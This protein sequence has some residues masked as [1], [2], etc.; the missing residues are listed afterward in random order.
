M[1]AVVNYPPATVEGAC[2]VLD[3]N[4]ASGSTLPLGV[5]T[6]TVTGA[7][8]TS[9][10]FNVT[11]TGPSAASGLIISE[12]RPRGIAGDNDEFIELYN[13][14]GADLTISTSDGSSGWAVAASDGVARC[15]VPNG[16]V[17][18]NRGHYLCVNS[19]GYSLGTYPAG[20]G[21]TATGDATYTTG[22]N[23]NVGI[24]L[25]NTANPANFTLAN[26]LDAVGSTSEANS[27]YREGPG[28]APLSNPFSMSDYSLFRNLGTGSPQDTNSNSAD[29]LYADTLATER[30]LG[31]RLGGPGPENLSSPIQRN[32]T[33]KASLIFPCVSSSADPNRVRDLTPVPVTGPLGTLEIRR[34]F[35][36]NTGATITRLRFRVVDITTTLAPAGTADLR[37]VSS[38]DL[39]IAAGSNPCGTG[40]IQLRGT[41]VETPPAFGFGGGLNTSLSSG[42]ITL[43]TPLAAGASINI[44][45]LLGVAQ[46]GTFRFL[47]NV[48]ALP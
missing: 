5:T 19:S 29:F 37:V 6:V 48:E 8:A 23:D 20:N 21:T 42:T 46:G 18:P 17:V 25:F 28:Y 27:L 16:T 32:A 36:N 4:P 40:A 2:G 15:T 45:L 41:A 38:N 26:R 1:S 34:A 3:Y 30:G 43:G 7:G 12:F 35:T 39:A 10:Q 31:R 22:I 33:V 24:A 47:V 9:C 11:V 13:N 44:R 14:S